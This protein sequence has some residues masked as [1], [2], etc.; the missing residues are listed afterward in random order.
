M[1]MKLHAIYDDEHELIIRGRAEGK[2]SIEN[3]LHAF[4]IQLEKWNQ[5]VSEK[6]DGE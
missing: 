5:S 6:L 3:I 2:F 4:R 1:R